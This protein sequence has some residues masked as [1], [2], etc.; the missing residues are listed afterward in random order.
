MLM[1]NRNKRLN[2][3]LIWKKNTMKPIS[4]IHQ[5][6]YPLCLLDQ[7]GS[8]SFIWIIAVHFNGKEKEQ[9]K[10]DIPEIR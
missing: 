6:L 1:F 5:S 7:P 2:F 10:P 8:I 9:Q 3:V 4:S